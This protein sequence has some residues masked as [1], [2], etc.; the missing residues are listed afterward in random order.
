M[1]ASR[2]TST[3]SVTGIAV[4]LPHQRLQKIHSQRSIVVES[5]TSVHRPSFAPSSVRTTWLKIGRLSSCKA[6]SRTCSSSGHRA[7]A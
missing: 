4:S 6:V 2:R 3:I 1:M 7:S 5:W